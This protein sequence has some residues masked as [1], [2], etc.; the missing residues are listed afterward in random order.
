MIDRN[1]PSGGLGL[2]QVMDRLLEDAVV[3]PRGM[4]NQAATLT[5]P[6]LNAYEEGDHLVVEAQLPGWGPEDIDVTLEQGVLTIRGDAPAEQERRG[7]TY[8]IREHRAGRFARSVRLPETV[9]EDA[10]R[11]DYEHGVLRLTL[12]KA[13]RAKARRIEIGGGRQPAIIEGTKA[14]AKGAAK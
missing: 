14:S 13:A 5:G 11:A 7:R 1:D 9:D 8:L 4:L 6:A 3:T 12:P 2:R 10:V